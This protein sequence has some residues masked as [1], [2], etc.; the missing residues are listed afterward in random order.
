MVGFKANNDN[1][2]KGYEITEEYNFY[3]TLQKK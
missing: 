2:I 3:L 1:F